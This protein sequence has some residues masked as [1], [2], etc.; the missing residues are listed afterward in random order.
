MGKMIRCRDIGVDCDFEAHGANEQE[1]MQKCE[2]HARSAHGMEQIPPELAQQVRM[3]MR[4]EPDE[5]SRI[6]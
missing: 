1:V 4:D 2:E 6:A 5:R 3:G